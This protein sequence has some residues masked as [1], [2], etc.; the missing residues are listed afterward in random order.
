MTYVVC[1]KYCGATVELDEFDF[2]EDAENFCSKPCVF[3]YAEETGEDE[4][5]IIY[6][7]EMW[8]EKKIG[9][10]TVEEIPFTDFSGQ[11]ITD[12]ELPF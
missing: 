9:I 4:D 1:A 10:R 5:E 8:I 12:E 7:H 2:M 6:P 3:S 11:T